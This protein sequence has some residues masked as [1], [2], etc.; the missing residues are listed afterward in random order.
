MTEEELRAK[1]VHLVDILD[2]KWRIDN[3]KAL[4]EMRREE[5]L[6]FGA[7]KEDLSKDS[8]IE[9]EIEELKQLLTYLTITL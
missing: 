8:S 5:Y 6:V 1:Y 4:L 7:T 9:A 2:I 3:K